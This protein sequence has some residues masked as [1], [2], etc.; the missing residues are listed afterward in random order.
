MIHYTAFHL[1]NNT[2][3]PRGYLARICAGKR[4]KSARL[5][6]I[7]CT[8]AHVRFLYKPPLDP[9]KSILLSHAGQLKI[10]R[11][12][13]YGSCWL[14]FFA[15]PVAAETLRSLREEHRTLLEGPDAQPEGYSH[16]LLTPTTPLAQAPTSQPEVSW[17]GRHSPL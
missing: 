14:L 5:L 17:G 13:R 8:H 1:A 6:A 2:V 3:G 10:R 7:T 11:A 12:F 16:C 9:P 4:W 15:E